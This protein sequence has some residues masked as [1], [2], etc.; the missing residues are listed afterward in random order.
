M[1]DNP[2]PVFS[3]KLLKQELTVQLE[4]EKNSSRVMKKKYQSKLKELTAEFCILKG[5]LENYEATSQG[6]ADSP[7]TEDHSRAESPSSLASFEVVNCRPAESSV[8]ACPR[9]EVS[10]NSQLISECNQRMIEKIVKLQRTLARKNEKIEF[11][12]E[13]TKQLMLEIRKKTK[14]V[15]I[16]TNGKRDVWI[17]F[18]PLF[19][20]RANGGFCLPLM[21]RITFSYGGADADVSL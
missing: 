8:E 20:S 13:N 4:D 18:P 9:C 7:V 17:C 11:M 14:N 19:F 16:N 5:K 2:R 6:S 10:Y 12:E 21:F 3:V 15:V 1:F